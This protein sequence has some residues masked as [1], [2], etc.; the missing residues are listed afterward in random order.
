MT[1][2]IQSSAVKNPLDTGATLNPQI[3]LSDRRPPLSGEGVA[4]VLKFPKQKSAYTAADIL[5]AG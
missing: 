5:G 1:N 3:T 2:E 4:P